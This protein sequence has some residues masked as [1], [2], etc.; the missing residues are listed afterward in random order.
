MKLESKLGIS[1]GVL[2]LAMFA[3]ALFAHVREQQA[4]RL[5]ASVAD[6]RIPIICRARDVRAAMMTSV[7]ALETY[8]VFGTDPASSQQ[9]RK[10]R[11]DDLNA[12]DAP[13]AQLVELSRHFDLGSD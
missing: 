1:T 5:A 13:L 9:L 3:S 8:M 10:Q 12:A 7:Q 2:I 6:G 11:L 4:N